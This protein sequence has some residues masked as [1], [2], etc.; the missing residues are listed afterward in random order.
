M[1]VDQFAMAAQAAI[2]G[3]GVAL[4]PKFLI[5]NELARG[6]L[7]EAV[8]DPMDSTGKYYL[9]WPAGRGSYPPLRAFRTWLQAA[10][11]GI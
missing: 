9:A 2:S 3:L 11:Q 8:S 6:D 4:L 10:V 1:L 7:V 5:E